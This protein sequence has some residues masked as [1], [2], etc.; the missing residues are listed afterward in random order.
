[1]SINSSDLSK[2]A[3]NNSTV[4]QDQ[5][6]ADDFRTRHHLE[7]KVIQTLSDTNKAGSNTAQSQRPHID[8]E[9]SHIEEMNDKMTQLN[10]HLSFEKTEDGD[11]NIV[12][13]VDQST[14]DVVRQIPTEDFLK[15]SDRI[16]DIMD[17]LSDL[18]GSL[19]NSKV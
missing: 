10:V 5:R 15:M 18:K 17:Q 12:K 3:F 14:G 11:K 4:R 8:I 19:V 1:M 7:S 6:V 9:P 2:Q 16:D 13:V